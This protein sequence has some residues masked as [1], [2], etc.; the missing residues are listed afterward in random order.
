[1]QAVEQWYHRPGASFGAS[2]GLKAS[3]ETGVIKRGI[4][5]HRWVYKTMQAQASVSWPGW[6][7]LVEPW[8]RSHSWKERSP[9]SVLINDEES[10]AL[11]IEVKLNWE[12]ERDAKL[13]NE[14]LPIVRSA[15]GLDVV[16]PCL[17][18]GDLRGCGDPVLLGLKE[19]MKALEWQK[20]Q[21][22]PVLLLPKRGRA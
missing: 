20:P 19:L 7:L 6:R 11:V 9:D 18:V 1:M 12:R 17:L 21:P 8:F 3:K 4:D 22:T 5:Y 15:F 14:Y 16:K 2:S 10:T 13:V